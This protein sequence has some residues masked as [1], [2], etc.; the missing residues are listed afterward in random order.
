MKIIDCIFEVLIDICLKTQ[1][2]NDDKFLIRIIY[3]LIFQYHYLFSKRNTKNKTRER[4]ILT[5][6]KLNALSED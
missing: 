6:G 3:T 5:C 1:Y 2:K 4:L